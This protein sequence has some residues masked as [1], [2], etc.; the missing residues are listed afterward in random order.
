MERTLTGQ[1]LYTIMAQIARVAMT[2]YA[3]LLLVKVQDA[4]SSLTSGTYRLAI[5]M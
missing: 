4:K 5:I 1:S 2:L 3:G